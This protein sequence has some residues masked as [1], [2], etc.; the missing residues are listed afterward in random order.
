ML[1]C[2]TVLEEVWSQCQ[3]LDCKLFD[4]FD[5]M[6]GLVIVCI[7]ALGV[8]LVWEVLLDDGGVELLGHVGQV[9]GHRVSFKAGA[10]DL[11][12]VLV[13]LDCKLLVAVGTEESLEQLKSKAGRNLGFFE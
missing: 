13:A 9:L 8:D 5:P 4:G 7:S 11:E 1:A 12:Q 10:E 3:L 2:K 6:S